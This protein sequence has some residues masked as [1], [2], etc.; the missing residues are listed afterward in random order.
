[1]LTRLKVVSGVK[2]PKLKWPIVVISFAACLLMLFAGYWLWQ[3]NAVSGPLQEQLASVPGVTNVVIDNSREGVKIELATDPDAN[4]VQTAETVR[5][6]LKE[7]VSGTQPELIWQDNRDP[8]L[9]QVRDSLNFILREAEYRHEYVTM[10]DR[11]QSALQHSDV[12]YQLGVDDQAIYLKLQQGDKVWLEVLPVIS[13][14]G[15]GQ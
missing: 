6:W 9:K 2:F 4:F 8:N 10:A 12:Q 3:R 11:V 14:G 15:E 5:T 1:M 13:Q 7:N